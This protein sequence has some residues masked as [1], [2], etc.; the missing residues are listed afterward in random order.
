M[1]DNGGNWIIFN[2]EIYNYKQIALEL[3]VNQFKSKSDTEMCLSLQ[4]V[5]LKNVLI[6][7]EECSA[8]VIWDEIKKLFCAEDHLV[9]NHFIILLME[10]NFIFASEIKTLLP[11]Y[12]R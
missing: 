8:F 6:N 5:V 3:N 4:E 9:L 2:G 11:F 10:R 7:L 1:S 12:L